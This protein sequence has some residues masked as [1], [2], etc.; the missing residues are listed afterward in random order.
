MSR[1]IV[2]ALHGFYFCN[3]LSG[4]FIGQINPGRQLALRKWEKRTM[5]FTALF[6]IPSSAASVAESDPSIASEAD[7]DADRS[8]WGRFAIAW[9]GVNRVAVADA[10]GSLHLMC[11]TVYVYFSHFLFLDPSTCRRFLQF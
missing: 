5:Q 2:L 11:V 3:H 9:T 10:T 1:L 7:A 4:F 6:D 8:E